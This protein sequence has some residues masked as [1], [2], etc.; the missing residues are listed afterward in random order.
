MPCQEVNF[1]SSTVT[2]W[3]TSRS[4]Q[5]RPAKPVT[6]ARGNDPERGA[7][8]GRIPANRLERA[9]RQRTSGRRGPGPGARRC[10][11]ARVPP[12]PWR[13]EPA[14]APGF[15]GSVAAALMHPRLTSVAIPVDDIVRR[16]VARALRQI[17]HGP[18]Q[19]PGEVMPGKLRI[20]ESTGGSGADAGRAGT[21]RAGVRLSAGRHEPGRILDGPAAPGNNDPASKW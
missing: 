16:V 9:Q 2:G 8:R 13:A 3:A 14:L 20:G 7:C 17:D 6:G 19:Q 12:A 10:G 11:R 15:E 1:G 5:A 21:G 18:D 4:G